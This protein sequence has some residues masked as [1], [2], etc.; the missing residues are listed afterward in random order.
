MFRRTSVAE[1]PIAVT[2]GGTDVEII[3][4][5]QA[6]RQQQAHRATHTATHD[7][8]TWHQSEFKLENFSELK[9]NSNYVIS[10][11][12]MARLQDIKVLMQLTP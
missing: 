6:P 3:M 2:M 8:P 12:G 4:K 5:K 1:K 10:G 9:F 11:I 7:T